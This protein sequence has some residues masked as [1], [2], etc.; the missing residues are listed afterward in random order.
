MLEVRGLTVDFGGVRALDGATLTVECGSV[1]AL[2]G[3]NGAGKT[4]FFNCVT[5][6]YPTHGGSATWRGKE[7]IGLP[8]HGIARTGLSRTFQNLA[9]FPSMTVLENVLVGAHLL[10]RAG[11]LRGTLRPPG[12]RAE[13][14]RT[15]RAVEEVIE[16]I[17]LSEVRDEPVA[18]L[19]YGTMK[20]VEMA[21]A[22]ASGPELLL[23]D[24][25]AAGLSDSEV[26]DLRRLILGVSER[27]DLTVLLV[28]HHMG[29]VMSMCGHVAVMNFGRTIAEGAPAEVQADPAVVEAYLGESA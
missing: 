8:P 19:P 27:R 4:T 20:R 10:G 23:L 9:L 5:G 2:I 17:G 3:P 28:E 18:G 24:E 11:F 13:E 1:T 7:L 15:R 6:L 12:V 16:E 22:L 14:R 29:L 25:P 21:R 26:E